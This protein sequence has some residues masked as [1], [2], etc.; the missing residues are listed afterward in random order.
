VEDRLVFH[1]GG[2][3]NMDDKVRLEIMS[4]ETEKIL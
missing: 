4:A 1:A 3:E 2:G